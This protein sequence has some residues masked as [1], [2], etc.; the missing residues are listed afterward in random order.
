MKK[1][2]IAG[3]SLAIAVL[4]V[5]AADPYTIADAAVLGFS[6]DN[7]IAV[8]QIGSSVY[9][10]DLNNGGNPL[11]F[12]E[13]EEGDVGY[14]VGSGNFVGNNTILVSRIPQ[15]ASAWRWN[16]TRGISSGRWSALNAQELQTGLGSPN[17][18]TPDGS[19]IAGNVATGESFGAQDVGTMVVPCVW[20]LTGNTYERVALPF[21]PVDYA[22]FAPQYVTANSI[23][24]DGN[25][26]VGQKVSNNGFLCEQLLYSRN[27]FGEWSCTSPFADL[28][29]PNKLKLPDYPEG[30]SPAVPVPENYLDPEGREAYDEAFKLYQEGMGDEP[31]A[32]NYLTPD[33]IDAYN[34]QVDIYNEWAVKFNEWNEVNIRILNESICFVFNQCYVSPNGRYFVCSAG[35]S[36]LSPDGEISDVYVPV[37]YDIENGC[38]IEIP[39]DK[40]ILVTGVSDLGDIIGYERVTDIDFGYALPAGATEWVPLEQYIVDRN[41][42]L[43]GWPEANMMHRIPVIINDEGDIQERDMIVTGMP[44]VSPDFS[45]IALTAYHFWE[46]AP[47]EFYGRYCATIVD[48][49]SNRSGIEAPEATAVETGAQLY[50]LQGRS[51]AKP[52]RGLYISRGKKIF[53]K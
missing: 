5:F 37:L 14:N 17:G 51:V 36:F 53:V 15:G 12:Y 34:R 40:S 33:S 19:R 8:S 1:I 26:I 20:N 10:F 50:D 31:D 21:D 2:F 49:G 47:D 11:A 16:S 52:C 45:H 42:E 38:R 32:A 28:I 25:H 13:S 9:F 24:A 44:I 48:L 35:R 23:S 39:E 7:S 41:S 4:P 27:A 6:P 22:G 18:V 3:S 46:D 30:E 29:N 43:A